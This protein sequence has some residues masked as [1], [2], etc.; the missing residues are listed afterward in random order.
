MGQQKLNN[1]YLSKSKYNDISYIGKVFWNYK[2]VDFA[3]NETNDFCF[4]CMC[5]CQNDK[6]NPKYTLINPYHVINGKRKSCGCLEKQQ[7]LKYIGQRFGS[8]YIIGLKENKDP[9]KRGVIFECV[10]VFCG[11][12][13]D[14]LARYVLSGRIKSCGSKICRKKTG[15]THPKYRNKEY[16]GKIFNYLQVID[17]VPANS[18]DTSVYWICKCLLDNN[19]IKVRASLVVNGKCT[20]CGCLNSIAEQVIAD[21]LTNKNIVYKRQYVFN[22]LRGKNNRLLRF[23]FAI[24]KENKLF[25]L[26]E[27]DGEHH[28][29]IER[30]YGSTKEKRKLNYERIV[31]SDK[32]KNEYAKIHNIVLHRFYIYDVLKNKDKVEQYLKN[33]NVI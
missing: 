3:I 28:R 20:S 23:D 4:K 32:K 30:A 22:D 8:L 19:L 11:E 24:F 16:I 26:I 10:C 33:I 25:C 12:H 1:P 6:P 18:D 14:Y 29:S 2:V 5:L 17:I 27:Y 15:L 7:Y 21:I 9:Y 13:R 31:E